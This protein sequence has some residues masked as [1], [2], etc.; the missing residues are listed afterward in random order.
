MQHLVSGIVTLFRGLFGAQVKRGPLLTCAL[1]SHLK[2][3]TIL[4]AALI[5]FA[6]LRMSIIVL[7]T[8][9]GM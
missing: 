7:E 1:N 9:R 6:L 5:Q 3:M 8:R 4:D 2:R